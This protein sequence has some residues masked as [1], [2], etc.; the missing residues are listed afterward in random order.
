MITIADLQSIPEFSDLEKKDLEWLCEHC[1][2][3]IMEPG[4]D[5]RKEGEP[6]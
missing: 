2:E 4:K 1:R 5:F 3:Q 6:I